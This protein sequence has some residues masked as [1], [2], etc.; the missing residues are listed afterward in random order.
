MVICEPRQ[1]C[2]MLRVLTLNV[3]QSQAKST[4]NTIIN[5]EIRES[6]SCLPSEDGPLKFQSLEFLFSTSGI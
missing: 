4:P 3:Q 5:L 2:R 6:S 1:W